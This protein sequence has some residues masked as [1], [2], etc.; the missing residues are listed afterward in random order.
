MA[1]LGLS[2]GYFF[3]GLV[4]SV[5]FLLFNTES[6]LVDVANRDAMPAFQMDACYS[7]Q[8]G[9]LPPVD[10]MTL[11][12]FP[13][14]EGEAEYEERFF[15]GLDRFFAFINDNKREA[16]GSKKENVVVAFTVGRVSGR[17]ADI[18]IE[19][20]TD[21]KNREEAL[22][23]INLL[24]DR[25]VRWTPATLRGEPSCMRLAIAVSFHGAGCG[26]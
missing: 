5:L 8:R 16:K 12:I 1:K 19:E 6:V 11:P 15:C 23:I 21:R 22:R 13:G 9:Q 3:T 20:G 2:S 7:V 18:E 4:L 25:D 26:D 17:M 24:A 10:E 14:C